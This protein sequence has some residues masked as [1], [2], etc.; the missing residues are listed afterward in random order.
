MSSNILKGNKVKDQA[1]KQGYVPFIGSSELSR[2]DSFHPSVLAAKYKRNY[3]PFLLGA[4]GTQSLTHYFSVQA[5]GNQMKNKKAVV[6]ISPQ[7]FVKK[8]VRPSMFDFYYSPVQTAYFLAHAKNTAQDRYAAKRLLQ[9]PSGT[10]DDV[11]TGALENVAL[12]RKLTSFQSFYVKDLRGKML[13]QEDAM[14]SED[15][16]KNNV[17]KIQLAAS[18]LPKT[19]NEYKLEQLANQM[20]AQQTKGNPFGIKQKFY[21]NRVKPLVKHLKGSQTNFNYVSSPEYADFELLL[22]QFAK[23]NTDVLFIIPPINQKWANYTG[24]SNTMIQQFDRKITYQL[25]SQGFNNIDD[26]TQDGNQKYFMEDTIHIGWRG[27]LQVDQRVRP[28]L[29]DLKAKPQNYKIQSRFYTKKWQT[30]TDLNQMSTTK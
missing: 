29:K 30:Q 5:M 3:R 28:F 6:I 25:Q 1:V 16:L 27:W 19:Y 23:E 7:W 2:M 8:G 20:G 13:K 14:F 4:A 9:L 26:L 24:L 11:V 22:N 12:G 15:F 18:K 21:Q 10:S 17:P